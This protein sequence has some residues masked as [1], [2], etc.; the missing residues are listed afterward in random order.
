MKTLYNLLL[1]LLML[2]H[3]TINAQRNCGQ[4]IMLQAIET[5]HAG[6]REQIKAARAKLYNSNST[7]QES[8]SAPSGKYFKTTATPL[9]PV[10]FHFL[11]DSNTFKQLGNISGIEAR[12]NSQMKVLNNDFNGLNADK[13]KV[14]SVW[15]SL[16]ANVGIEF[17]LAQIDPA[18]NST[19]GYTLTIVPNASSFDVSDGAKDMKFSATGGVDAWDNSKYLNIWVG[20]I[21]FGGANVLG[22]TVPPATPLYTIPEYGI[23]LHQFAFGVRTS[24][25]QPFITNIDKGRTLT[26][27][28]GHFLQLIHTWGDDGGLCAGSGGNDDDM[29]DTPNEAD[30]TFG[31]PTFPRFDVCTPAG[32]GIMFMNYMD[33]TNDSSMYMFTKDQAARMNF[34]VGLGGTSFSLTLNRYLG[35]TQYKAPIEIKL[36]PNP[37]SGIVIFQYDFIKNPLLQV[38]V[39]NA[40]G[41]KLIEKNDKN[42]NSIDMSVLSKGLYFVQCKF[43]N[44]SLL[45]KIIL[46]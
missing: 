10:V 36:Y 39:Y 8:I 5:K 9:I 30:A 33:Y 27:E 40:L 31:D 34:E 23:A 14:P 3:S 19:I 18:G 45:Q 41:Q 26:H 24:F 4:E 20:N 15:T 1:L 21:K 12:L 2:S 29:S 44:E 13:I 16:Y 17:A 46:Q 42:I 32:N 37:T 28:M 22:V 38:I 43:A 7:I 11:L 25:A 35:D 6:A